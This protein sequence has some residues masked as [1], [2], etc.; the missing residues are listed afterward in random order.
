MNKNA[1]ETGS[2]KYRYYS[3]SLS[4]KMVPAL[5]KHLSKIGKPLKVEGLYHGKN[6]WFELVVTGEAGKLV[7]RGCSW[8]YYG[9]GPRATEAVLRKLGV[10]SFDVEQIAFKAPQ[11][12][13]PVA[14]KRPLW[15]VLLPATFAQ[16]ASNEFVTRLTRADVFSQFQAL[17]LA[18][19]I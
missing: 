18:G 14:S 19:S 2:S 8:G 15:R 7:L 13:N 6:P 4:R 1:N 10:H 3:D 12:Q 17:K 16:L 11:L 5:E 9:E